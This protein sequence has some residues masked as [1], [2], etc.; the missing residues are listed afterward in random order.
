MNSSWKKILGTDPFLGW[1]SFFL[2]AVIFPLQVFF[3]IFCLG[4]II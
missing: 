1:K 2:D 3:W 4:R